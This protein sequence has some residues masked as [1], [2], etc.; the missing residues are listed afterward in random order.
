[1]WAGVL[2]AQAEAPQESVARARQ[3]AG[4]LGRTLRGRLEA[5]V[6][7]QSFTGALAVCQSEAP[8]LAREVSTRLGVTVG[9]T[10]L[11]VRNE[12]NRPDPWERAGLA[13]LQGQLDAGVDPA[14]A[15]VVEVFPGEAR[16]LKAIVTEPACLICHGETLAPALQQD[17]LRRYPD[18]RATGFKT[19][20]L[21]GAFTVRIPLP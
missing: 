18:D 11:R 17:L 8:A 15:E 16:F 3:A 13:A 20:Q 12:A 19:G 7:S 2:L 5:A 21:R 1:M 14:R 9:R 6:Q 10:A 4:E